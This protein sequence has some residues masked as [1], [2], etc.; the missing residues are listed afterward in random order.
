MVLVRLRA[1]RLLAAMMLRLGFLPT[2]ISRMFAPVIVN[3]SSM[4]TTLLDDFKDYM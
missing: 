1:A 3:F 4:T 2:G